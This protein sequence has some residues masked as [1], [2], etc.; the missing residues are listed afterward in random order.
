MECDDFGTD[1]NDCLVTVRS[2]WVVFWAGYMYVS[3]KKQYVEVSYT[4]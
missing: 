3:I 4:N 2:Q 1:Q